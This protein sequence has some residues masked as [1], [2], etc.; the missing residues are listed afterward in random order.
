MIGA[1]RRR[2]M[3]AGVSYRLLYLLFVRI[4]GWLLLRGRGSASKDIELPIL[5]HEV[6]VPRRATPKPRLDWADRAVFAALVRLSLAP[7]RSSHL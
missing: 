2:G 4:L 3:I 7:T 6:A 5:R 1:L